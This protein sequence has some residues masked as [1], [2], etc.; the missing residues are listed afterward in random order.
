MKRPL[1]LHIGTPKSG[2]T[3]LQQIFSDNR[4]ELLDQGVLY[5]KSFGKINLIHL[6]LAYADF[7]PGDKLFARYKV[8][9]LKDQQAFKARM[10]ESWRREAAKAGDFKVALISNEH[11]YTRMR[12]AARLEEMRDWLGQFFD[13]IRIHVG[14][15]PQ[16]D[17]WVSNISQMAR[18]GRE[19]SSRS[20]QNLERQKNHGF[21]NYGK[22]LAPWE[23]VFGTDAI[24]PVPLRR[25]PD[26]VTYFRDELGVGELRKTD[27]I[28]TNPALGWKA[29]AVSNLLIRQYGNRQSFNHIPHARRLA[30]LPESEPLQVGMDI[31]RAVTAMARPGNERLIQKYATLEIGDFEPDWQKYQGMSNL[32]LIDAVTECHDLM[33]SVATG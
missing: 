20:F 7:K 15:R 3:S 33:K 23:K 25:H 11:L 6:V 27:A 22:G 26:I 31:A 14:L 4:K 9:T 16:I 5:P 19:V 1:I 17:L 28:K 30:A 29:I 24:T 8:S 10:Q 13:P 2:T 21:L 18:L 12:S 32:D